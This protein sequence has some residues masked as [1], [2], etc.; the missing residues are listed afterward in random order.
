[1]MRRVR[2][3]IFPL[4][5]LAVG[6]KSFSADEGA[7]EPPVETPD[8]APPPCPNGALTFDGKGFVSVLY[9]ASFDSPSDLTVEAWVFPDVKLGNTLVDVVSHHDLANSDGW[10]LSLR[11]HG[12]VFSVYSG[13]GSGGAAQG[14]L[15]EAV[16]TNLSYGQWHHIAGVFDGAA[17]TIKVFIDGES[18]AINIGKKKVADTYLGPL[19]IGASAAVEANGYVGTID[20]V[21][22]SSTVR[23]R[24]KF[25]PVYPLPD[26]EKETVGT[27]HFIEGKTPDDVAK[28]ASGK[29]MST[30]ATF[31][32][33]SSKDFPTPVPNPVCPTGA[34]P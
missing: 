27:W 8:A 10:A 31:A 1:M 26:A 18:Q 19:A 13:S 14:T 29:F 30:L 22:V 16:G 34:R 24:D 6:C 21:R 17:A 23:Y 5:I 12:V 9:D 28:E 20:E 4:L 2:P 33:S 11:N 25:K 32:N 7:T 15:E 3:L